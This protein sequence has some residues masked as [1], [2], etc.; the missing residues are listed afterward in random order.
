[1]SRIF[2]RRQRVE[3]P[4]A[5]PPFEEVLASASRR[6]ALQG[7]AVATLGGRALLGGGVAGALSGCVAAS[8]GITGPLAA[9]GRGGAAAGRVDAG[10]AD[11]G[12]ANPGAAGRSPAGQGDAAAAPSRL[13]FQ[14][15]TASQEDRVRVPEG[16]EA[17]VLI[18]WGDPVGDP[19]GMPAFRHDASNSAQEQAL[20]SGTHHD[21]MH[22]F[23]LPRVPMT[24][25]AAR[26]AAQAD[27]TH[28]LLVTNHEYPDYGTLF[29]DHVAGWSLE[30]VRKAQHALGVS[31]LEV[32]REG[33][34][35]RVVRP[36]RL[37]RRIH[38][39]T[40]MRLS[41]PAAGHEAMRTEAS[42][43]GLEARGTF[44]NC[45]NGWTPWGTYLSCEENFNYYFRGREA[46]TPQEARYG[47]SAR[48]DIVRWS[49]HDPRFDV[50]R[51]PNEPNHFGW[52]VE[53]DPYDPQSVPVKRTALG[54]KKQ[55]AAAPAICRDGRVAFYMGDDQAFEYLYKFVTARPWNPQDR[56]ANRDLLDEGTLYAARFD[57][58]GSGRWLE[59]AFGRNG[60]TPANGFRS[61]AEVLIRA[62]E[63]A[64]RAG[65][66]PMDRPEW[67]AVDPASGAVY[68]TLT[69]N[70]ARGRAGRPGADAANPRAPNRDGHLL[71]WFEDGGDHAATRFRWEIAVLAG[72][73]QAADASARSDAAGD[74]F[75]APD[76]LMVDPRGLVWIQTD[77]PPDAPA[78]RRA[79]F[80]NNQLLAMD[81]RTRELRRFLTGP[82]GCEITG[83]CLTPDARTLF[84]NIQHP[85]EAGDVGVDPRD[86]RALSNWPD[87]RPDG[88]PR[89]ATLTVR[90]RDGG[91]IGS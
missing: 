5:N 51:H 81:P 70:A 8:G 49:Q 62:R 41:G 57:A 75:A 50:S 31:V 42:P 7:A 39:D 58:D 30:K 69:G 32:V 80:G 48:N 85:G 87:F 33:G 63:A 46:P 79:A 9:Q 17:A 10:A 77:L 40:P 56:A 66:T 38:G 54:R 43:A 6:Q 2:H 34:A 4:S 82:R 44:A 15:I 83:A 13:G 84:V 16:Y 37:A 65:A 1:M 59:L 55:E 74:A 11:G 72:D 60:L 22:F 88:R 90:R 18:R 20:Q 19:R 25:V 27:S 53:I 12:A 14:G 21:G 67:T 68:A 89:S 3:N 52:V 45:A 76:G 71:R 26:P 73:P 35:W 86:P 23:P 29:P 24:G 91:V 78:A 61:Q 64:D 28:G 36:S 47:I